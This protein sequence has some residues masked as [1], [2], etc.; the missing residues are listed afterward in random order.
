M[1][2]GLLTGHPHHRGTTPSSCRPTALHPGG[3][4]VGWEG[5]L[6]WLSRLLRDPQ[7]SPV[8][9]PCPPRA[10]V[11]HPRVL[12]AALH[13]AQQ[14][15]LH[16]LPRRQEAL[17]R[18]RLRVK[19]RWDSGSERGRS[20]D[21]WRRS[22]GTNR[23]ERGRS[24]ARTARGSSGDNPQ[25]MGTARRE[26]QEQRDGAGQRARGTSGDNPPGMG[27]AGRSDGHSPEPGARRHR[28]TG[29]D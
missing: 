17:H 14:P 22:A 20:G 3:K 29:A 7:S 12:P 25:G 8:R 4:P 18:L 2:L 11:R 19:E 16:A 26:R 21:R 5:V 13:Q 10:P 1:G 6:R 28:H 15:A 23:R 27:T 24:A 9:S